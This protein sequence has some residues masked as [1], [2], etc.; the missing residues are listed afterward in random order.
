[1]KIPLWAVLVCA[2]VPGLACSHSGD[3]PAPTYGSDNG[4][5]DK[6]GDVTQ[7]QPG[8]APLG[9]GGSSSSEGPSVGGT[10]T[11]GGSGGGTSS[12]GTGATGGSM[13][14]N[15]GGSNGGTSP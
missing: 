13:S 3:A 1:M 4:A 2:V 15:T 12:G 5:F 6:R 9:A 8:V 14:G 11:T 7:D 10:N